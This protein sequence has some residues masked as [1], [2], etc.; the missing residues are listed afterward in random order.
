M[1]TYTIT[2]AQRQ[3]LLLAI[4]WSLPHDDAAFAHAEALTMLQSLTPLAAPSTSASTLHVGD[5]S[6]EDWF[7]KQPFLM[8]PGIKQLCRDSYAA[9]MGDPLVTPRA[10]PSTSQPA[11]CKVICELC[12][13]RGYNFCAAVAKVTPIDLL[14]APS[15]SAGDGW[16]LVPI[17]LTD[18]MNEAAWESDGVDYVGDYKRIY[19]MR[20]AWAAMLAAAP[21]TSPIT[22]ARVDTVK[23]AKTT[24]AALEWI[25][26]VNA[27]DYE[28]QRKARAALDAITK[29]G[30]L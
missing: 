30:E 9:G 11:A 8:Q 18:E 23:N 20:P 22:D 12:E 1:T 13:K 3:Q 5:S 6:F 16:M 2:E 15:T 29:G 10:A 7:Q 4:E 25:A 19:Q 17:E 26:S 21:S 24:R 14:A 28:Y 27:T